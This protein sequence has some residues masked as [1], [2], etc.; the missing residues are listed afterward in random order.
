[1]L[2]CQINK[3]GFHLVR[4]VSQPGM[5]LDKSKLLFSPFIGE[6][7][8]GGSGTEKQTISVQVSIVN[9]QQISAL[10]R[11]CLLTNC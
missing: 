10:L 3:T 9:W 5:I 11:V 2:W 7:G 1:M 6:G 8:E 4:I